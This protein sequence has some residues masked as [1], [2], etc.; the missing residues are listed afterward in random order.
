M[1][2]ENRSV[3]PSSIEH[4][5]NPAALVVATHKAL[6]TAENHTA[7][8]ERGAPALLRVALNW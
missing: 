3:V 6:P 2:S 8:P 7:A 5:A 4:V 1:A